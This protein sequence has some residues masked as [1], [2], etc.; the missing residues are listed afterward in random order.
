MAQSVRSDLPDH[1]VTVRPLGV[2]QWSW[3]VI[4]LNGMTVAEGA[5]STRNAAVAKA[6]ATADAI[7]PGVG[8]P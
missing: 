4:D 3:E 7:G 8:R 1:A 6:Y 5:E 2:G